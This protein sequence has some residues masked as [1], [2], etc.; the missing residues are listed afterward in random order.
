MDFDDLDAS[1][2]VFG[3][4]DVA[5]C[6]LGTT[7]GKSGVD[8]L[9]IQTTL[10]SFSEI[11]FY[12]IHRVSGQ[13][14]RLKNVRNSTHFI[15]MLRMHVRDTKASLSLRKNVACC[16]KSLILRC[17]RASCLLLNLDS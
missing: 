4:P 5:I 15:K 6:C 14:N 11:P 10:D 7:R 12:Y 2:E 16:L 8:G 17:E 1:R 13:T 3:R 9:W